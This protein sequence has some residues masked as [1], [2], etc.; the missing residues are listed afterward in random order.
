[1]QNKKE[2]GNSK[3][4]TMVGKNTKVRGGHKAYVVQLFEQIKVL[5]EDK[6]HFDELGLLTIKDCLERKVRVISDLDSKILDEL[7]NEEEITDEIMQADEFQ[8]EIRMRIMQIEKEIAKNVKIDMMAKGIKEEPASSIRKTDSFVKLPKLDIAKFHGD[9]KDFKRFKDS[10]DVAIG[11][12]SNVSNVQKLNYLKGFLAN[13]AEK[14][15]RGLPLT[16]ENYENARSI[17]EERFGSRQMIIESHMKALLKLNTINSI[18]DTKGIRALY[19]QIEANLRSLEAIQIDKEM[20]GSLLI[21][22]LKEKL[23]RELNLI[24]SRCFNSN[25]ETWNITDML[26][27]LRKEIEARERC[28]TPSGNRKQ[29]EAPRRTTT[30]ALHTK[31]RNKNRSKPKGVNFDTRKTCVFCGQDHYADKCSVVTNVA[32]RKAIVR[33][34][35]RCYKCLRKNH[36]LDECRSR[37]NCF[38]CHGEHHTSIC[39]PKEENEANSD[40]ETII[41]QASL[42]HF[43]KENVVLLETA[44]AKIHN[45]KND[46]TNT[47]CKLL[48]DG[49]SQRTYVTKRLRNR[50]KLKTIRQEDIEIHVF[51][52]GK[53]K[54]K[55]HDIVQFAISGRNSKMRV[56]IEAIVV[57]T[58]SSDL[59]PQ[60]IEIV[61]REYDHLKDLFLADGWIDESYQ[62]FEILIGLDNYWKLVTGNVIRGEDGP[63][64]LETRLG[65][66]LSGN[67]K[68]IIQTNEAE[69]RTSSQLT[70]SFRVKIEENENERIEDA[71]NRFWNVEALGIEESKSVLEITTD[72]IRHNGERYEVSLPWRENHPI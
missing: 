41:T 67:S 30:D 36:K 49:G 34:E 42:S 9:P 45:T 33:E 15:I 21:P 2:P 25:T 14:A 27:A 61:A 32:A 71:I 26:D 24:V 12:N 51:G 60:P 50:L 38:R 59:E 54:S 3:E 18:E 43:S 47:S 37:K 46:T 58:I 10:F 40:K 29:K 16:E 65:Y 44:S 68:R 11:N 39:E 13:D 66:V 4:I 8:N 20:Y 55:T 6:E 22:L 64:A 5:L 35:E 53:H 57:D 17:L 63:V 7:E 1:M 48:F 52:G 23:P 56:L 62:T 70:F 69:E 31:N 72:K 19:D 28:D